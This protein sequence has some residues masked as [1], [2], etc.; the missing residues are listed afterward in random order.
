MNPGEPQ[1]EFDNMAILIPFMKARFDALR[2][3]DLARAA[4]RRE[5]RE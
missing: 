2:E 3:D 4:A 5:A 1:Y